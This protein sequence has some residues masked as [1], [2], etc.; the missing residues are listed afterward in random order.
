MEDIKKIGFEHLLES[1]VWYSMSQYKENILIIDVHHHSNKRAKQKAFP[2]RLDAFSIMLVEKGEIEIK[3][4]YVLHTVKEFGLI[5]LTTKHI[6]QIISSSDDFKGYY[7]IVKP[8]YLRPFLEGERPPAV[9]NANPLLINPV[10]QLDY[11]EFEILRKNLELLRWNIGRNEHLFQAKLIKHELLNFI[12]ETLNFR[13][14]KKENKVAKKKSGNRE[15]IAVDFFRLLFT[16]IRKE[17]EVAF[18]ANKLYV[19]PVYLSRAVKHVVGVSAMKVISDMT[20]SEAEILLRQHNVTIQQ[21][22]EELN[23]P[24]QASFS[25]YFKKRTDKSP[26]EYRREV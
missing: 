23:F 22:A 16:H 6:L 2:L 5:G 26:L 20:V 18:Y 17:R 8:S 3:I 12:Y 14:L 25:K 11:D 10:I 13:T 15:N 7:L 4:D 9:S 21:V 1:S 19:S 24:D